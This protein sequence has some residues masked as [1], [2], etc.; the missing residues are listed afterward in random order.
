MYYQIL[1]KLLDGNKKLLSEYNEKLFERT[2]LCMPDK[3]SNHTGHLIKQ[4]NSTTSW[5]FVGR[6]YKEYLKNTT[7]TKKKDI[8]KHLLDIFKIETN[9]ENVMKNVISE[10]DFMSL[11]KD[12][13]WKIPFIQNDLFDLT[14]GYYKF[15]NCIN[16]SDCNKEVLLIAGT[17]VRAYSME[18][19]TFLLYQEMQLKGIKAN[20]ILSTTAA[21][22]DHEGIPLRYIETSDYS[23]GYSYRESDIETPYIFKSSSEVRKMTLNEVRA[24]IF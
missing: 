24:M 22:M 16:L 23:I 2:L 20:L 15:K 18:L 4:S 3:T 17:T 12:E 5:G 14:M 8:L 1:K 19:N 7:S 13:Q 6:N 10:M 21:L 11:D 9:Y